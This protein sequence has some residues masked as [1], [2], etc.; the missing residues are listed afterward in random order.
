MPWYIW[1]IG[2][3]IIWFL[4]MKMAERAGV[5]D[6]PVGNTL[7]EKC[8]DVC[9]KAQIHTEIGKPLF[10]SRFSNLALTTMYI[11]DSHMTDDYSARQNYLFD[12]VDITNISTTVSY[13]KQAGGV[14]W[15]SLVVTCSDGRQ[16]RLPIPADEINTFMSLYEEAK[17]H[18]EEFAAFCNQPQDE[19]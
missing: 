14:A 16:V 15:G 1:V 12:L 4:I 7:E 10:V 2:A 6:K 3:A 11:I 13:K 19:E 18:A 5:S 17:I 8:A 9:Q